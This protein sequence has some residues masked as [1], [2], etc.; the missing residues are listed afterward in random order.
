MT[1]GKRGVSMAVIAAG[2]PVTLPGV[3]AGQPDI[4]LAVAGLDHADPAGILTLCP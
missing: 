4:R 1:I 3:S 2:V